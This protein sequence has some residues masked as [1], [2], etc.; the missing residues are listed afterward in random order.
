[1]LSGPIPAIEA[2]PSHP[3]WEVY[4]ELR[5]ARMN[6]EYYMSRRDS[7]KRLNNVIEYF[8]AATASGSAIAAFSVWQ[9]T[10]GE[11]VWGVLTVASAVL[12]VY[13]P[14]ARLTQKIGRVD[15]VLPQYYELEHELKVLASDIRYEG[16]YSRDHRNRFKLVMERKK[17]LMRAHPLLS[18]RRRLKNRC[19]KAAR[20]AYPSTSFFVPPTKE[21]KEI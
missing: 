14:I 2:A 3:V 7:M 9:T 18:S 8:L 10:E 5:T 6:V 19:R 20:A 17:D 11:I 1:M 15:R 13:K 16:T 4:D 12:A 21:T